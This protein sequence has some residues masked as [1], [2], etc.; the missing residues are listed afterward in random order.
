MPL[1]VAPSPLA[2]ARA[3]DP[4]TGVAWRV[5]VVGGVGVAAVIAVALARP[6]AGWPAAAAAAAIGL[7]ALVFGRGAARKASAEPVASAAQAASPPPFL[8]AVEA[9]PDPV[10]LVSA[11]DIDDQ[12]AR[13]IDHAN[14]AARDLL[15][16]PAAGALLVAAVRRPE[17]LEALDESLYG[18]VPAHAAFETAAGPDRFLTAWTFPIDVEAAELAAGRSRAILLFRDET[19]ARRAERTRVDFLAN[20]SHELRTPLASLGGFIETLRGHARED[21]VARERF[22]GIMAAQVERMG[23]LT[24]DLLLL[25]RAELNEHVPPQGRADLA[26]V[27]ADVADAL[28]PLAAEGAVRLEVD[29]PP[30]GAAEIVGDRDQLLQAVQNL[31]ANAIKYSPR[32][33][34]VTVTLATGLSLDEAMSPP[35]G[36]GAQPGGGRVAILSPGRDPDR[37]YL[38]FSVSDSGPG[39]RRE[40]LPRLSERFYRVEGQKSGE[41]QGTGLG[42]AIVKHIVNRHR[43]GLLAESAPGHGARFHIV[44]PSP[45]REAEAAAA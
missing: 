38:R 8:A 37:R 9:L 31:V 17:V 2:P 41:R 45:L 16:I 3:A 15:R 42:L 6:E 30:H 21:P 11:G 35:P 13:R 34:P 26:L 33:A 43:G 27:A 36:A 40:Q 14:A 23:R 18:R 24:A 32:D 20:A 22:L 5:A 1:N 19:E 29:L 12:A 25:S 4:A 10:L 7:S 28:A 39:I 44:L